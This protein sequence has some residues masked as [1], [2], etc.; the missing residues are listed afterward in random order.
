M[1]CNNITKSAIETANKKVEYV[2][3]VTGT[4]GKKLLLTSTTT[5]IPHCR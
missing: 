1:D 4:L 3:G 5:L 2:E